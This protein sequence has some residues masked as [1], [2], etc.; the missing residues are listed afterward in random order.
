[1]FSNY[2]K[3]AWRNIRNNSVFS[4][5]NI[6]GLAC[7]IAFTFVIVAYAWSEYQVNRHLKNADRQYIIQSKWK[8]ENMGL[9]IT[10]LGQLAKSLKENYP[11]LV[12]NYYRWDGITSNIS[13]GD[14]AFREGIQICDSTMLN[15]YGFKL[16]HGNPNSAFNGTYSVVISTEKA[17]KYFGKTDVVG[18]TLTVE[19]FSGTK[20]DFMISGVM[21]M[22]ARN[23]VTRINAANDNQIFIAEANL[24]FF[25][26]N[27]DWSNPSIVNYIELQPGV[28]PSDLDKPIAHLVKQNVPPSIAENIQPFL[29]SLQSYH[30]TADNGLVKK[31]I[32]ALSGIAFFIL[33]MAVI[34][35]INMSVSKASRRMRE[36]GIRKV[37]GSMK[38]Q[39]IIQFLFESTM[40]VAFASIA[41]ILI[42]M[43]SGNLFSKILGNELP[44]L[45]DFP[46]YFA[47]LVAVFIVATGVIAGFY[48][49]FV[50][51][52]MKSVDSLKGKLTTVNE[53]V[54]LRKGL[55]T[56]Q[57]VTATVVFAGSIIISKQ[58]N[59]FFNRDLGYNK[60]FI[61][62][63]QVSRD[64]TP[65]G[66]RKLE[67]IRKSFLTIPAVKS[68]TASFE[69]PDG[70]N[71]GNVQLYKEGTDSTQ[72]VNS[73]LLMCDEN[74]AATFNIPMAAGVFFSS[75]G[76][77]TDSSRIVINEKQAKAFGWTAEEAVNKQVRVTN[78]PGFVA[79]VTGVVKDFH[80]ESM[81][82]A[83]QPVTFMH[84]KLTN[85]YR[86]LTFKLQPGS[87]S[88]SLSSLQKRWNEL[89]HGIPF[90]YK[91]MDENLKT[92][93]QSEMQL[94]QA[95]YTATI[96]S[97]V[98]VLLGVLGLISLSLHKRNKE[99]GIR[100]VLGSSVG[101]IIGLFVKEFMQV[102]IIAGLIAG[103]AAYF[104]MQHWL[105]DYV[106]RIELNVW[107]IIFSVGGLG[108]VTA[109]LIVL[110]T[111]KA[112]NV[113]PVKALRSE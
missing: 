12:A 88:Q 69:V 19:S 30:L 23:S 59:H 16:K 41:A 105:N 1:M 13:K 33:L 92:L 42:Y 20:K 44:A 58:I 62:S 8:D 110:Q 72:S 80:F 37:L 85:T 95:A 73:Q 78:S 22:P 53:K 99:I 90:E 103:P 29:V 35:F 54:W 77:L 86:M 89:L 75:P 64:W 57:F 2:L 108:G 109:I 100:K 36:I 51:S 79:T 38:K 61:V 17:K 49:A 40:I 45:N 66:I 102:I 7:G 74:Y 52:A 48:P 32:Y 9:G 93:Y 63:A 87:V 6:I 28:K 27:M 47:L 83:I 26:R 82:K 24:A 21:E 111:M 113:N 91:F 76:T 70:R 106:Y 104:L 112:A 56:L 39:I 67:S 68:A 43:I 94:R 46:I 18:E 107:P 31:M 98:I 34:N 60:D 5:I 65:A 11:G 14:K 101:G 71:S 81:Q 3:L 15:M 55:V 4:L 84:L 97:F 50:L 10:T 25:S 96:L